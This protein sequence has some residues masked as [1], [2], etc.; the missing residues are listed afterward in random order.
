MPLA[1]STS[2]TA[3]L[4]SGATMALSVVGP[5]RRL[6][7]SAVTVRTVRTWA[8]AGPAR[9][10]H[11]TNAGK[12]DDM[13][14]L[15][16]LGMVAGCA[17][18][19]VAAADIS[20]VGNLQTVSDSAVDSRQENGDRQAHST[21]PHLA[22]V[23]PCRRR[24]SGRTHASASVRW[25]TLPGP[26]AIGDYQGD[27]PNPDPAASSSSTNPAAMSSPTVNSVWSSSRGKAVASSGSGYASRM[28]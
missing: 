24:V 17:W 21:S 3:P 11:R 9:H 10:R 22:R 23:S 7:R 5:L 14:T 8:A 4:A 26:R 15:R 18:R 1:S 2:S 20:A 28:S 19:Q 6:V 16:P 27:D 25:M 12:T 13:S